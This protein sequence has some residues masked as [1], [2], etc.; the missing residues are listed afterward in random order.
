MENAKNPTLYIKVI[1]DAK[2][3]FKR[4]PSAYAS[5]WIQREYKKR[6]GEYKTKKKEGKTTIWLKE[7]W[8]QVIPYVK[9][10]EKIACGSQNKDTKVCRPLNKVNKDTPLTLP[11]LLQKHGKSNILKLANMKN[12][13]MKGRVYWKT[14][15][16]I[17]SK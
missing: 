8:I 13:D 1:E 10:G 12:K 9:N 16:F 14:M 15:I 5:M 17:P 2:K 4:F 7:E 6:G 3:K 11:L